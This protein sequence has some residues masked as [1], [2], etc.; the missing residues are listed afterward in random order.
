MKTEVLKF[1]NNS[2]KFDCQKI[3]EGTEMIDFPIQRSSKSK[4][5]WLTL[6]V[7]EIKHVIMKNLKCGFFN[8]RIINILNQGTISKVI[9]SSNPLKPWS[10][11]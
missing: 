9:I 3:N 6:L 5:L 4:F 8:S 2:G 11:K 7:G 1:K 10:F